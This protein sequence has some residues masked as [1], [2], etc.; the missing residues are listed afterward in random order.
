MIV[1]PNDRKIL[2]YGP[3][4]INV[5]CDYI[6]REDAAGLPALK[7]YM[8]SLMRQWSAIGLSAPQVGVFKQ[9][10]VFEM[11]GGSIMEMVNPEITLMRGKEVLGMEACLSLP[12][13]HNE[14]LVPR[15]EHITVEYGTSI[16]PHLRR[17]V[18]L[19]YRDAVVAQHEKD[20]LTGNFF[21]DRVPTAN[22]RKVLDLF[23]NWKLENNVNGKDNSRSFATTCA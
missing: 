18:D 8:V 15:M 13:S 2:L 10:F 7:E 19:S 11:Q 5:E 16:E 6:S 3:A 21:F 17:S 20:H 4:M 22:K 23:N 14:C 1:V 9:F 12:P